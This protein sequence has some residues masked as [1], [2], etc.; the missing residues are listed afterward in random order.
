L[1]FSVGGII[2][3]TGDEQKGVKGKRQEKPGS[4]SKNPSIL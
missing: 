1:E 2:K 4:K 3:L